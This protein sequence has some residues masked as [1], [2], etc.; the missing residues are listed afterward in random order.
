[1]KNNFMD[2]LKIYLD[3]EVEENML[4]KARKSELLRRVLDEES[5]Y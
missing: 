5:F 1:M 3:L 2:S 4:R